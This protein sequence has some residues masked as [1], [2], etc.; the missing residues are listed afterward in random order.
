MQ[1]ATGLPHDLHQD[2]NLD[3]GS[4]EDE[5]G[6]ESNT[7]VDGL[8]VMTQQLRE[9]IA[10]SESKAVFYLRSLTFLVLI[11]SVISVSLCVCTFT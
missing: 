5:P 11:V 4:D 8:P 3:H 2:P 1:A 10:K 6:S 9:E 7:D